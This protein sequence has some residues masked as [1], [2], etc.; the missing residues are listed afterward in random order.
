MAGGCCAGCVLVFPV[1]FWSVHLPIVPG[2]VASSFTCRV[3]MLSVV[4]PFLPLAPG[5]VIGRSYVLR[6]STDQLVCFHASGPAVLRLRS[7]NVHG[8]LMSGARCAHGECL[9]AGGRTVVRRAGWGSF[10]SLASL[11]FAGAF[12]FRK[13]PS[14]PAVGWGGWWLW[15]AARPFR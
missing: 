1:G 3:S 6:V 15:S 12:W 11:S 13:V 7:L 2:V 10:R 4:S 5:P 8:F 9:R 14:L